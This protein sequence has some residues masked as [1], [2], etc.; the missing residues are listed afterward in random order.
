MARHFSTL[1]NKTDEEL[2]AC[3]FEAAFANVEPV[4]NMNKENSANHQIDDA[5]R[6]SAKQHTS[7]DSEPDEVTHDRGCVE[8]SGEVLRTR[9]IRSTKKNRTAVIKEGSSTSDAQQK[10]SAVKSRPRSRNGRIL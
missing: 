3:T 8:K 10:E 7:E 6:A 2:S 1:L 5:G 9:P 4:G